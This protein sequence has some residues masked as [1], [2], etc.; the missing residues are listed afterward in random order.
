[1][2]RKICSIFLKYLVFMLKV[3]K[4][5]KYLKRVNLNICGSV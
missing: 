2:F 4:L 1:M 5:K 3:S